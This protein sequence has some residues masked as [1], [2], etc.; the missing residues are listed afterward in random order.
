VA[1]ALAAAAEARV[2]AIASSAL[3]TS[4]GLAAVVALAAALPESRYAH[5]A[6]TALLLDTDVT[7]EPLLPERGELAVRRV[8]PDLVWPS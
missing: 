8:V 2:P 4:V 5:G 1:A 3:E 6:G 7:R